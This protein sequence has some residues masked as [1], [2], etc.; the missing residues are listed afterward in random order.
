MSTA[1][2]TGVST[3]AHG[4]DFGRPSNFSLSHADLARHIRH[5]RRAGW[6]SWEIRARFDFRKC[7]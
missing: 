7:A 3:V 6:Q 2:N 4:A 1:A 5:L